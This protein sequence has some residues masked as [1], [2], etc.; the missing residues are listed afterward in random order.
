MRVWMR[1]QSLSVPNMFLDFVPST[2]EHAIMLNR[3]F[4]VGFDDARE[5]PRSQAVLRNQSA[6]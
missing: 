1:S 5:M 2:I 4:P 6:S 3:R